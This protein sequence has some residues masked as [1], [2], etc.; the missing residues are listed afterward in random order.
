M[1]KFDGNGY[2]YGKVKFIQNAKDTGMEHDKRNLLIAIQTD[3]DLDE[4]QIPK[5]LDVQIEFDEGK[6]IAI[7]F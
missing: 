3:D 5:N 1:K 2:L 6:L 4:A 7:Y